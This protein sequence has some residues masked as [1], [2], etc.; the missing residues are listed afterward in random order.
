MWGG[1]NVNLLEY[2]FCCGFIIIIIIIIFQNCKYSLEMTCLFSM[3]PLSR[4][5]FFNGWC[6]FMILNYRHLL[7][8]PELEHRNQMCGSRWMW[9]NSSSNWRLIL[10]HGQIYCIFVWGF[11]KVV[12]G[13]RQLQVPHY[14]LTNQLEF[15]GHESTVRNAFLAYFLNNLFPS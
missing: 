11:F 1:L 2:L 14:A 10:K 12:W 8:N 7:W 5:I 15:S 6:I 4:F 13:R 9:M 3:F